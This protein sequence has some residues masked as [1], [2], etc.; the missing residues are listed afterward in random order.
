MDLKSKLMCFGMLRIMDLCFPGT[1]PIWA[2]V[3]TCVCIVFVEIWPDMWRYI[4]ALLRLHYNGA[5][6]QALRP[7]PERE[8]KRAPKRAPE[9]APA[10]VP[11][12]KTP[13][14]R[15][16]SPSPRRAALE[17]AIECA[18]MAI[19][20]ADG[21]V[22]VIGHPVYDRDGFEQLD[23]NNRVKC[24]WG[25]P[26]GFKKSRE[27]AKETALR[28]TSE[29]LYQHIK[30]T[31]RMH[32]LFDVWCT[33]ETVQLFDCYTHDQAKIL[34]MYMPFNV[35]DAQRLLELPNRDEKM[36]VK[37][38]DTPLSKETHGWVFVPISLFKENHRAIQLSYKDTNES[39]KLRHSSMWNEDCIAQLRETYRL[40][41][42]WANGH[43]GTSANGH[44]GANRKR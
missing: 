1:F 10:Q 27:S 28:E 26:G 35:A 16:R 2:M 36:S 9:C 33:Q 12:I 11:L 44:R 40:G 17:C 14:A 24:T 20:T 32:T 21:Y 6:E 41:K 13:S 25:F 29:E 4:D 31:K 7:A 37:M 39:L 43:Q 15:M 8:P 22:L 19:L 42:L 34:V 30:Y 38:F 3:L 23:Q 18:F 5:F